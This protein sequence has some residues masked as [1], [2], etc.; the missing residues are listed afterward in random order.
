MPPKKAAKKGAANKGKPSTLPPFSS[1]LYL[2]Q[3]LYF[4]ILFVYL[5]LNHISLTRKLLL[6]LTAAAAKKETTAA[7]KAKA[8]AAA[9]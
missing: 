4:K 1:Y 5:P 7:A 9:Q 3:Y 8:T 2:V 6:M